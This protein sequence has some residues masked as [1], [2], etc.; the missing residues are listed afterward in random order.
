MYTSYHTILV[1]SLDL[2]NQGNRTSDKFPVKVSFHD[3]KIE[4]DI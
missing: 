3:S 1:F 4:Q 2:I